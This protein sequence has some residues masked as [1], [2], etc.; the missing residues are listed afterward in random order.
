MGA[1]DGLGAVGHLELAEDGGDV[2]GHRLGAEAEPLGDLVVVA[3]SDQQVQ[4]LAFPAV[5]SRNGVGVTGGWR[6]R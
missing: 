3:T 6:S 5:S 2:V 1:Q 4:D